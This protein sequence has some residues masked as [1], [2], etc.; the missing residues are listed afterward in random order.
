MTIRRLIPD[1]IRRSVGPSGGVPE[2]WRGEFG[3]AF[4]VPEGQ[5]LAVLRTGVPG[6]HSIPERADVR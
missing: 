5:N 3:V 1:P 6:G 4:G 2:G